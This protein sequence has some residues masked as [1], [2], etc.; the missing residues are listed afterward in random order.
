MMTSSSQYIQGLWSKFSTLNVTKFD[1]LL[2][3]IAFNRYDS[4]EDLTLV[5]HISVLTTTI[6]GT[7]NNN[8]I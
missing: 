1:H 6:E 8:L 7:M 2:L 4:F 5:F 3:S